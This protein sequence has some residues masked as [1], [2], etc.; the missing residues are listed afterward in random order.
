MLSLTLNSCLLKSILISN[1]D[2]HVREF[3]KMVA[4]WCAAAL[5]LLGV[6]LIVLLT[7]YA[8]AFALFQLLKS[9]EGSAIFDQVRHRLI[10]GILLGLEFLVAAD[11]VHTVAVELSF[12]S[13]GV[14]AVVVLIRTFLS[15]TLELEMTGYW[16]WQKNQRKEMK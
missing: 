9:M 8:L 14:L 10:R 7:L 15:F 13:V 6:C 16:P 11:I 1:G 4:E 2:F 5:E 3:A 12:K